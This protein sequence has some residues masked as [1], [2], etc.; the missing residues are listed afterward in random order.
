VRLVDDEQ[1]G[2]GLPQLLQHLLLGQLLGG[3]E[4]ELA[5]APPQGLHQLPALAL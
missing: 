2:P 4:D 3:E 5:L 1:R